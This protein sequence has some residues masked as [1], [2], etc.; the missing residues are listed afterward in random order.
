M[1]GSA[2]RAART[3]PARAASP[4]PASTPRP[5]APRPT[6]PRPPLAVVPPHVGGSGRAPFVLLVVTILSGGLIGLLALNTALAQGSFTVGEL[7]ARSAELAD[8]SQF[9]EEELARAQSPERLA[10]AARRI[11]MVPEADPA[12]IRLA[13][14]SVSG[15]ATPAHAAP[16]PLT[17]AEKAARRA[18][19]A[20]DKAAKAEKQAAAEAAAKAKADAAAAAKA[21]ADAKKAEAAAKAKAA[22]EAKAEAAAWQAK[23]ANQT[24]AGPR[25]GGET[26]LVPPDPKHKP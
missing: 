2:A 17:P 1:S 26:V 13:D 15:K 14:G 16:R 6:P 5:T 9:L 23:L 21:A 19:V 4:R 3:G 10:L 18:Q 8:R 24:K 22:A 20:A 11:G 25:S 7:Q 12:F